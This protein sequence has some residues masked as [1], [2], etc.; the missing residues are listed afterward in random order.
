MKNLVQ[1]GFTAQRT[2]NGDF[3]PETPVYIEGTHLKQSGLA[4]IEEKP[5]HDISGLIFQRYKEKK[6]KEQIENGQNDLQG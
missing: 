4:E 3:L 1:V 6:L 5:L 2:L